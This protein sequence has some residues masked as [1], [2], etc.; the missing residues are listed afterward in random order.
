MTGFNL[1][2]LGGSARDSGNSCLINIG[3]KLGSPLYLSSIFVK[4]KSMGN[5]VNHIHDSGYKYLFPH[6]GFIKQ[7]LENFID[8]QW[9]KEIDFSKLVF[10]FGG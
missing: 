9:V 6:S 3:K 10:T 5:L 1:C 8:M 2:G 4:F 7:L